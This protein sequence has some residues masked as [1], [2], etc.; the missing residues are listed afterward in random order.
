M[1]LNWDRIIPRT[2]KEIREQLKYERIRH[3]ENLRKIRFF[4]A[5]NRLIGQDK[6]ALDKQIEEKK[7]LKEL[8]QE[9]EKSFLLKKAAE[10]QI[11]N[12]LQERV[13]KQRK[14]MAREV[15]IYRLTEQKKENR[16]E[17]DLNDPKEITNQ[18]P[19]RLPDPNALDPREETMG[20]FLKFSSEDYTGEQTKALKKHLWLSLAKQISE[21]CI[22]KRTADM[23]HLRD[24][25]DAMRLDALMN[26]LMAAEEQRKLDEIKATMAYNQRKAE[27]DR[28]RR[29]YEKRKDHEDILA[30]LDTINQSEFYSEGTSEQKSWIGLN[31]IRP[32]NYRGMTDEEIKDIKQY[33][34][35]QIEEMKERK[36]AE[37]KLEN[38]WAFD[39]DMMTRTLH[40][41]DGIEEAT[42]KQISQQILQ[43]NIKLAALQ[44][45]QRDEATRIAT[46]NFPTEEYFDCW[47]SGTR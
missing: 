7:M 9:K 26:K 47:N 36:L 35:K 21:N 32:K 41:R 18:M 17:F 2:D 37:K 23:D 5:K 40:I 30:H 8:E 33:Q 28:E 25:Q 45:I 24:G 14:A 3:C 6:E 15:D 46:D 10:L 1:M 27:F 38:F 16:R 11:E 44:Q 42:R 20:S 31:Q 12:S 19:M 4:N 39:E 29:E 34:L 13:D 22:K 43:E